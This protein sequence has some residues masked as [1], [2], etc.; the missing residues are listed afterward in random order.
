MGIIKNILKRI[1][2][3]A[4]ELSAELLRETKRTVRI[5][6]D[7]SKR[8]SNELAALR[9]A[10]QDS[11][12][13]IQEQRQE[14]ILTKAKLTSARE[15]MLKGDVAQEETRIKQLEAQHR[16]DANAIFAKTNDEVKDL[17]VVVYDIKGETKDTE[18]E[19]KEAIKLGEKRLAAELQEDLIRERQRLALVKRQL[20][21][22]EMEL[23]LIK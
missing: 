19:L 14:L 22:A 16:Q 1:L 21:L 4:E 10:W 13:V 15:G 11:L 12:N 2:T 23:S 18:T 5:S 6:L 8:T 9:R 7:K 20:E 3:G 17:A